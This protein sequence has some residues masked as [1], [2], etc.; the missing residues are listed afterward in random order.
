MH[1]NTPKQQMK[2]NC[3]LIGLYVRIICTYFLFDFRNSHKWLFTYRE[4]EIGIHTSHFGE[5]Q[6]GVPQYTFK[7][8]PKVSYYRRN[9]IFMGKL[10]LP[11]TKNWAVAS[12]KRS[13]HTET[14]SMGM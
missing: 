3:Y 14:H 6:L 2:N 8:L 7:Q 10:L 4:R 11:N 1:N 12:S 13:V 9:I 5:K